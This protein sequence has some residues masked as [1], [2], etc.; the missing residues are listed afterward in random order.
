MKYKPSKFQ[1]LRTV[2]AG[3]EE[4]YTIQKLVMH[5]TGTAIKVVPVDMQTVSNLLDA[6]DRKSYH[7]KQE[8]I[9]TEVVE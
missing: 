9:L 4:S 6:R 5:D 8:I 3:G 2:R 1:I 7:E